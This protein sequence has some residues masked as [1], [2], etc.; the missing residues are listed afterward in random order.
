MGPINLN[1]VQYYYSAK[2]MGFEPFYIV[3]PVDL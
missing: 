2:F 3:G 1:R